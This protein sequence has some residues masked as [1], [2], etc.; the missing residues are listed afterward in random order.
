MRFLGLTKIMGP[1][2]HFSIRV[3]TDKYVVTCSCRDE[4][5][6]LPFQAIMSVFQIT[7]TSQ[8][9]DWG[10]LGGSSKVAQFA[11]ASKIPGFELRDGTPYAE[12]GLLNFEY[13][14]L[15]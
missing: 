4:D 5:V 9:Y 1:L 14:R 8:S 12:V 10:K 2:R 3:E 7:P 11:A 15:D 6:G 13:G